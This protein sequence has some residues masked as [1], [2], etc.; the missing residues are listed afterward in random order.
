M[1]SDPSALRKQSETYTLKDIVLG[2]IQLMKPGIM[3]LLVLEAITAMLVASGRSV[4]LNGL[5]WLTL[6]GIL[7]SG[8]AASLNQF[9]ERDNDIL[10]SRTDFR[11]VATGRISPTNSMI[12]GVAL[13][14]LGLAISF[15]VF[16]LMTMSMA[17]LGML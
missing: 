16:N 3:V 6:V 9:L 7:S 13:A 2:Y 15:F 12:F 11:P 4:S 8:G 14:G 10:M 17:L 5:L 1:V